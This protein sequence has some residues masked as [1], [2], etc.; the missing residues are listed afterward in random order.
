MARSITHGAAALSEW[1]AAPGRS[2]V[3]LA[4][5]LGVAQPTVSAWATGA[6]RPDA[7]HREALEA[8]AG[9]DPVAWQTPAER[10][11]IARA[12]AAAQGSP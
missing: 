9:I 12:R 8:L 7:H 10:E 11:T 6:A 1:L 5:R 3:S 4:A 2:Q